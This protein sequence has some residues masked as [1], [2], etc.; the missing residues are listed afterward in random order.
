MKTRTAVL[1]IITLAAAIYIVQHLHRPKDDAWHGPSRNDLARKEVLEACTNKVVGLNRIIA[2]NFDD[3]SANVSQWHAAATLE[4]VNALGG[5][6]RTNL[7]FRFEGFG[8][9]IICLQD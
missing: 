4:Y 5:V 7:N 2:L 3:Q 8:S 1:I 9:G 6:Q